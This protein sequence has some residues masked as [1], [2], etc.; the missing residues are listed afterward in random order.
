MLQNRAMED[1]VLTGNGIVNIKRD[2]IHVLL[3]SLS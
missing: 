1:V 2:L 3:H